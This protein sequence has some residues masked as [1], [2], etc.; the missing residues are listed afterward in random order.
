MRLV[1][2]IWKSKVSKFWLIEVPDLDLAT[3]GETREEAFEMMKDAIEAHIDE[4]GVEVSI[5]PEEQNERLFTLSTS[6]T[7]PLVA[8]VL[9]RQRIKQGLTARDAAQRMK[10]SSPNAYARYE[11][12]DR[13]PSVDTFD[14]LLRTVG[15]EA[16]LLLSKD[17][18]CFD[19]DAM[20]PKKKRSG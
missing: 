14:E 2:K 13:K 10:S 15:S 18:F 19:A 4:K 7:A 5:F 6:S 1:G 12:S 3:Q 20:P 9:K 17:A 16:V 11:N 8:L